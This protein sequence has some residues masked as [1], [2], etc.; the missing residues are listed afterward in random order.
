MRD[1]VKALLVTLSLAGAACGSSGGGKDL[2]LFVGVWGQP[3]GTSTISCTGLSP[4]TAQVTDT[5]T[6]MTSSTS[7]LVQSINEF[8]PPCV[9]H[10]DVASDTAT[11][12]SNQSCMDTEDDGA[13]STYTATLNISVYKFVVAAD[14]M[15][16]TESFNGNATV[17]D[18]GQTFTCTF[19]QT[20]SYSKQ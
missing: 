13:G 3:S 8:S 19:T 1:S 5:E 20:A 9:F 12:L 11:G 15:T 14:D 4:M 7:D 10:A 6:W 18:Q 17:I 2:N 16:A